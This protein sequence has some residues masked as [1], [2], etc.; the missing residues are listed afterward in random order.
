MRGVI[1]SIL[2]PVLL[3]LVTAAAQLPP[4][5]MADRYLV[6]V[7]RLMAEKDH[8]AA[9][10]MMDR[11]IALQK[12]HN[13]TVPDEFHFKYA[14][15][16]FSAG[17]VK[18]AL[19]SV[20]KYLAAA[21][22]EGRFYREALELLDEAEQNLP[23]NVAARYLRLA[24]GLI[25]VKR[26]SDALEVMNRIVALEREHDLTLPEEF[27]GEFHY[28][29][30]GLSLSK[31]MIRAAM[32]SASKYLSE[33]GT[34][35]KYHRETLTLLD[36]V[37]QQIQ[38]LTPEM[39]VIPG[40]RFQMGC[41]SGKDCEDNEKPVHE[42]RVASLEMS[43]YEVTFEEYDRFTAATGRKR[44]D[45]EGWGRGR[46]PVINVSWEDAVAYTKWLSTKLGERYR[47]PSNAEWEYAA[48][49][50]S[51]TK[52]HFGNRKSQLCRYANHADRS[53]EY[54]WRN[55]DCSDG[56]GGKTATVGS[57]QPNGFGLY[58]M[59]GNVWEWV[60]DCWNDNYNGAPTDG[61]AWESGGCS[62][63]AYRGGSW[64]SGARRCRSAIRFRNSPGFRG[65]GQ[66]FRLLKKE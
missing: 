58:D 16:A 6:R 15:I 36:E 63:R 25:S 5:I 48:R 35:G 37:E 21:G 17:A 28:V 32:D 13:L 44:P 51:V 41:V 59:H 1:G 56:V 47:L 4:E 57:Y 10:E 49:S 53:T 62:K 31:G 22:R 23:E 61:S 50:G 7:E 3:G 33:A 26:Y 52:Y 30:A 46:R 60:Q 24:E 42:V 55:K 40:G 8:E 12:E 29:H 38:M 19:D 34:S 9:L 27:Q 11:I 43:K 65:N 20:N 39:V 18:A 45:D 54:D 14:Q 2:I 66:G 64:G